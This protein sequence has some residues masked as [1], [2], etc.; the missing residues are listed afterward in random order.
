[1]E[2]ENDLKNNTN[3]YY[4]ALW[5]PGTILE[6][7]ILIVLLI[8]I[9]TIYACCHIIYSK[10]FEILICKESRCE[11]RREKIYR[12]KFGVQIQEF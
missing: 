10:I 9:T 6:N 12:S 7:P 1:M 5:Q 2:T 4:K 11:G 8:K 3:F